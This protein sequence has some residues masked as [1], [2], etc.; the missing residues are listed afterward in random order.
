[1]LDLRLLPEC[2]G[3]DLPPP[4]LTPAPVLCGVASFD[5]APPSGAPSAGLLTPLLE[6]IPLS[7]P[8]MDPLAPGFLSILSDLI[9][10]L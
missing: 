5:K 4:A 3:L 8:H 1:M 10:S 9:A 2:S 6:Y 7:A